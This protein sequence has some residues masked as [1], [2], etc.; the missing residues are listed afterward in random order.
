M[1]VVSERE[2]MHVVNH[3]V[4]TIHIVIADGD[5]GWECRQAQLHDQFTDYDSVALVWC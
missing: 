2:G 3:I 1:V 4:I 5:W